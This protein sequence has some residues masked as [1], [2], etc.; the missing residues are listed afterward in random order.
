MTYL[1]NSERRSCT[2]CGRVYTPRATNKVV[3]CPDCRLTMSPEEVALWTTKL[4]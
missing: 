1:R 2:R 3:L 4:R